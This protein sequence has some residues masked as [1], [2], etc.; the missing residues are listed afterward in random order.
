[1][2]QFSQSSNALIFTQLEHY[3]KSESLIY[4]HFKKT[5]TSPSTSFDQDAQLQA[6]PKQPR[7][8]AATKRMAST[9]REPQLIYN[10]KAK[11]FMGFETYFLKTNITVA[12][13]D[14]VK[15]IKCKTQGNVLR[16]GIAG[17]TQQDS[18]VLS[19]HM[20]TM[21]RD[22][23]PT[24][25]SMKIRSLL[26]TNEENDMIFVAI[27]DKSTLI[28]NGKRKRISYEN[29]LPHVSTCR[30][31]LT[32]YGVKTKDHELSFMVKVKQLMLLSKPTEEEEEECLFSSEEEE[33]EVNDDEDEDD[34]TN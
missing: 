25:S 23:S 15:V 3:I 2:F 30:I 11:H 29:G 24:S 5:M 21:I 17:I 18:T 7:I 9:K 26:P 31:A 13:N 32:F 10:K 4:F 28:F 6:T 19:G 12:L 22:F 20:H 16:V 8:R 34:H 14:P 27:D 1:M 33:E